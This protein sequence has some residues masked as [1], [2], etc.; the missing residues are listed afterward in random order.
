MTM[1]RRGILLGGMALGAG[2]ALAGTYAARQF[3]GE[4]P[5]V[6]PAAAPDKRLING[7]IW[8]IHEG[9][10]DIHGEWELLGADTLLLQWIVADG[11]AYAPG[12]GVPM[13]E[14]APNWARVKKEPWARKIILGLAGGANEP[15]ARR[16]IA[17]LVELSARIAQKPMPFEVSA[18]YFPVEADP[19]WMDVGKMG[20]LLASASLPRPLWV[21]AYDNSNIGAEP[22]AEWVAG[23]LPPDVGLMFQDG[24]GLH[25]R[26][27]EGARHYG[28]VLRNRLG[29]ARF[30]MIAEAFRPAD[31]KGNLRPATLNELGPQ[32]L[33]YHGFEVIVFE[34]PHYL[35]RKLTYGL[36]REYGPRVPNR[37]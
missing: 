5:S 21:S 1:N 6:M 7:I 24:V 34:G 28:Q 8:Q 33:A 13:V 25:M 12:L 20:A 32:L 29:E 18:Y 23:W 16:N 30:T 35:D 2:L 3:T 22:F 9:M 15:E 37:V 17:S 36:A 14:D 27:P 11:K 4:D 19:T 26:T 31:D 10:L